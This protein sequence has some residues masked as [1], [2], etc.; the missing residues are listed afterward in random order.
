MVIGRKQHISFEID[1][2]V[3]DRGD[4]FQI[5]V[6]GRLVQHQDVGA[7]HHHAGEHAPHLFPAGQD[8]HGLEHIIPGEEHFAQKPRR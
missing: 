6:V 7:E 5:Q 3:V 2:P 4:G 1:Q 8:L